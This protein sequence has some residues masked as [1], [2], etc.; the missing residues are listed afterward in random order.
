MGRHFNN[1]TE[2]GGGENDRSFTKSNTFRYLCYTG[3]TKAIELQP[4]AA[5]HTLQTQEA[6]PTV[7]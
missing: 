3:H 7:V 6:V 5:N 2:F 4:Y 1:D